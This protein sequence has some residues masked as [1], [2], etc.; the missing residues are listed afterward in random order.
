MKAKLFDVI[1]VGAGMVGLTAA[2]AL[3]D[4]GY[5]V[6]IIDPKDPRAVDESS[7]H[8]VSAISESSRKF[9]ENLAVW[10]EIAK[11][12]KAPYVDMTVWDAQ[13]LGRINFSAASVPGCQQLGHIVYNT[14]IQQ[15]TC[16]QLSGKKA[17]SFI[18]FALKNL[19]QRPDRT[20]L[21]LENGS[22]FAGKLIV[23]ADGARSK[24][25]KLASIP[26]DESPYGNSAIVATVGVENAHGACARQVYHETPLAFLPL[27]DSNICSI[28]WSVKDD[29]CEKLMRLKD[30]DF[31]HLLEAK[32]E[33]VY[34]KVQL[35]SERQ[36]FTLIKRHSK[37][38]I[39][40]R[41][42]LVG[43][44]KQTLHPMAGLGANIGFADVEALT[45]IIQ[46]RQLT[47]P[48]EARALRAYQRERRLATYKALTLMDLLQATFASEQLPI[49]IIRNRGLNW[50]NQQDWLKNHLISQAGSG[51]ESP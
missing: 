27:S 46:S 36:A 23:A 39:K 18:P 28:V 7:S 37:H 45:N 1:V 10:Q 13:G 51:V 38:Y 41:L 48:G 14:A 50:L 30:V 2:K 3:G 15:A 24:V 42:A 33:G 17:I 49:T 44:A 40:D 35:L 11:L 32:M 20:L 22:I 6:A 31:C 12:N 43:D 8:R 25:R 21:T 47:D 19:E 9:L 29:D 34:G 26:W 5:S 4:Q 16:Q